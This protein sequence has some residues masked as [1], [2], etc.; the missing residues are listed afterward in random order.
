[1]Q[2]NEAIVSRVLDD[3]EFRQTLLDLYAT[4]VYR[5]ARGVSD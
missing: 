2:G 5:R 1:M 3:E 4:R